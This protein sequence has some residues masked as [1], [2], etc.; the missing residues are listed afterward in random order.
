[1]VRYQF[2][3]Q[4]KHLLAHVLVGLGLVGSCTVADKGDYT[5]DDDPGGGG[6]GQSGGTGGTAGS[7]GGTGGNKGGTSGEAGDG[8]GGTSGTSGEAGNGTGGGG[9]A[10]E[11]NPCENGDCT[12]SGSAFTCDCDDGWEGVTCDENI[13]DCDPN[14]CLNGGT[15]S[16]QV[17]DFSCACPLVHPAFTGKRCELPRFQPMSLGPESSLRAVS[18][19]GTVVLGQFRDPQNDMIPFRWVE[20]GGMP[21]PLPLGAVIRAHVTPAALS[22]DGE[23]WVGEAASSSG[24]NPFAI[25][26][27]AMGAAMFGMLPN[28]TAAGIFDTNQDGTMSVGYFQDMM[29]GIHAVRWN[30]QGVPL[31]FPDPFTGMTSYYFA[32]AVSPDGS[33]VFGAARDTTNNHFIVSWA[34][35]GA[36]PAPTNIRVDPGTIDVF[37]RGAGFGPVGGADGFV[38]CGTFWDSAGTMMAY[39]T[40]QTRFL[41]IAPMNGAVRA[42]SQAWEVSDDGQFIVGEANL[43]MMGTTGAANQAI[44]W[45]NDGSWRSI[46]DLLRENA[47]EPPMGFTLTVAYGVSAD[48]KVV[49]GQGFDP[50]GTPVGFIARLP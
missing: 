18:A 25:G 15:C 39:L 1:M 40:Q 41:N 7:S 27:T 44:I 50:A 26:G 31:P 34:E 30:E 3:F 6:E 28:A 10:C 33:V 38:T 12:A 4:S 19:D 20:G 36:P 37:P 35:P 22:S 13:D 24:G 16:D 46:Y 32:G 47:A 11:P 9:G 43:G 14:P 49:V 45:K 29:M 23:F 17:A 5:F 42:T 8:N 48:G 21:R 2:P